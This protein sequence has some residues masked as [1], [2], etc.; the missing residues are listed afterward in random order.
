MRTRAPVLWLD[1]PQCASR[2]LAVEAHP[3]PKLVI[4]FC[5]FCVVSWR[6]EITS[7]PSGGYCAALVLV[8]AGDLTA[9]FPIPF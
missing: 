1:C 6:A 5:P 8:G 2:L 7:T 9:D 3:L 4:V